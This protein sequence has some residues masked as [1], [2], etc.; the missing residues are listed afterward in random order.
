MAQ[1]TPFTRLF[2][3]CE[4]PSMFI[5]RTFEELAIPDYPVPHPAFKGRDSSGARFI[6]C[7][8]PMVISHHDG[9]TT[10]GVYP[11]TLYQRIG[12]ER[13]GLY[14][15]FPKAGLDKYIAQRCDDIGEHL[16]AFTNVMVGDQTLVNINGAQIEF[17]P[18]RTMSEETV[19]SQAA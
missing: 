15:V 18:C 9:T 17:N 11:L 14:L 2:I 5:K 7:R 16:C 8:R 19:L 12:D 3:D 10:N 1:M 13:V 4:V 6:H